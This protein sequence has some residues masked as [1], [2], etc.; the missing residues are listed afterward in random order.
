MPS[1]GEPLMASG[2]TAPSTSCFLEEGETLLVHRG[3]LLMGPCSHLT[4]PSSIKTH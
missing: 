2:F 3:A 4:V 1:P